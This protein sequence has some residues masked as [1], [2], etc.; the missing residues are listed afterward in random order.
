MLAMR[1][2]V[3]VFLR[4]KENLNVRGHHFR[5]ALRMNRKIC[6]VLASF[7]KSQEPTPNLKSQKIKTDPKMTREQRGN[8]C[9]SVGAILLQQTRRVRMVSQKQQAAQVPATLFF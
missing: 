8:S 9:I 4:T 3:C 2:Y 1:L 6:I 7:K 5:S